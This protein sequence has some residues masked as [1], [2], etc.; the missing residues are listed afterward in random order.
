MSFNCVIDANVCIKVFLVEP[1]STE[2]TALC[3]HL[4]DEVPAQFYAPDLLYIECANI[5]WKYVS[6][7]GYRPESAR[8]D[9]VDILELP[10]LSTPT[11]ELASIEYA[12]FIYSLH[13][14]PLCRDKI[15]SRFCSAIPPPSKH[16]NART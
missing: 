5:L 8:Q 4:T 3:T 15:T 12:T 10:I 2:A 14:F 6:H 1:L 7:Y 11:F 9:L 13:K 16:H